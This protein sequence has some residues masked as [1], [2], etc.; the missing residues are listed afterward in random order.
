MLAVFS[1]MFYVNAYVCDDAFITFRT[2]DNVVRGHGL[3]WN[4]G[5]RVQT[6]TSP[7]HTLLLS[8]AYVFV[9]DPRDVPNPDRIYWLALV[10]SF[11]ASVM[12]LL[13]AAAILAEDKTFV[14]FGCVLMSSQA[15]V[16]FTSSG[17]ETPLT[18]LLL[19]LLY[20]QLVRPEF[21]RSPSEFIGCV[22]LA[23]LVL[24]NRLDLVALILP[25]LAVV[26]LIGWRTFGARVLPLA[27]VGLVPL[28]SWLVFALVYFGSP[29][30][31]SYYAKV[32][33][34][35]PFS[36]VASM[37]GR[38]L[39]TSLIGDPATLVVCAACVALGV[40][41]RRARLVGAAVI[42]HVAYVVSIGGDFIGFRFLGP[43][44]LL[45]ALAVCQ[46]LRPRIA[47]LRLRWILVGVA[48]TLIYGCAVPWS[49]LRAFVDWPRDESSLAAALQRLGADDPR[50]DVAFYYSASALAQWRPGSRFPFGRFLFVADAADCDAL[51]RRDYT[52]AVWGDGLNGF[53]RGAHAHL[54]DPHGITDPLL[55]RISWPVRVPFNPGHLNKP[56]PAGYIESLT[57]G[58]NRIVT[59][60]LAAYYAKLRTVT[61][62]PLWSRERWR[63]LWELNVTE[64]RGIRGPYAALSDVPA[65]MRIQAGVWTP[66]DTIRDR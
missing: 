64:P 35:A 1:L 12:V 10:V 51:R 3:R 2:V 37:G 47:S 22:C 16:T 57:T 66:R 62:G 61:A 41:D 31:N 30:P 40:R 15:F 34:D 55:A 39:L 63:L 36:L 21:P 65:W 27:A 25:G 59:P 26:A 20:G 29:L 13:R 5:E 7:L 38:Y 52:V 42:L 23:A 18:Y 54:I 8:T 43:P 17:L 19:V 50:A 49:P 56:I 14:I 9:H 45:A 28:V 53:C 60:P 32:H 24:V 6:F 33:L 11:A 58:E 4:V 46:I 48:A 44:F